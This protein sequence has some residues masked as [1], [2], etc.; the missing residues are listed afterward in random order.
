MPEATRGARTA[1]WAALWWIRR[2]R[3]LQAGKWTRG[4][5]FRNLIGFKC[6]HLKMWK[7][8]VCSKCLHFSWC[9]QVIQPVFIVI[10]QWIVFDDFHILRSFQ[11]HEVLNYSEIKIQVKLIMEN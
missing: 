3:S 4:K 10:D 11:N 2:G 1:A 7:P 9:I 5:S 6:W 8:T